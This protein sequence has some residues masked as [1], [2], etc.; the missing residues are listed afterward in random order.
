MGASSYALGLLAGVLTTLSPC[1]LP[2]L[3]ILIASAAT[4]DRLGPA[5][6]ACGL[7]LSFV[8]IGLFVAT[9]GFGIGLDAE[10]FAYI[11]G[12][13]MILLGIVLLSSR[14]QLAVAG[15]GIASA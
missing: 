15:S 2:L 1:V 10:L 11:A 5:A 12:T 13:M 14:L 4:A 7:I 3:P 8:G 9:I 6:L